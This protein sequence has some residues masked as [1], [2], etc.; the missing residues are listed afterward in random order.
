MTLRF[1][2]LAILVR[3]TFVILLHFL[4]V[5]AQNETTVP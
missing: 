4:R 5:N 1:A 2:L 3:N